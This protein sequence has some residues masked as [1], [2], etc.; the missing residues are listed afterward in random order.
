MLVDWNILKADVVFLL[1]LESFWDGGVLIYS[2]YI[3]LHHTSSA[4]PPAEGLMPG[5]ELLLHD[6]LEVWMWS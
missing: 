5:L 4:F 6:F 2:G 3:M 1:F